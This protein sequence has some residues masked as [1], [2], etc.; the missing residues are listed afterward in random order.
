MA[1]VDKA[2]ALDPNKRYA[3]VH[4]LGEDIRRF[5]R[6]EPVTAK[7]DGVLDKLRRFVSRHRTGDLVTILLLIITLLFPIYFKRVIVGDESRGDG[8]WTVAGAGS[9]ALVVLISPL[10]GA[11]ADCWGAKSD[12][13]WDA[14]RGTPSGAVLWSVERSRWPW[15]CSSARGC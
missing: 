9:L 10:V 2:C 12:R 5:L 3:T 15:S 14:D 8:L 6:D 7:R 1:I 4:D 11:C 13:A